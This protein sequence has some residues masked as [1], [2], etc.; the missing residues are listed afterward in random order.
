MHPRTRTL[1]AILGV[2]VLGV[3]ACSSSTEQSD[4]TTQSPSPTAAPPPNLPVVLTPVVANVIAAP[5]PAP[6]TDGRTHLA[7]ELELT[8]VL[9][10]E[11][12]LTSIAVR[13]GGQP[14]LTLS[15]D[16]LGYWTR[17]LGSPTPT[18]KLGPGQSGV[19]W[20]DVVVDN[21]KVPTDLVHTV[22][23]AVP[24][25]SPPM[26][27]A[28]LD[29]EVAPV[30]VQTRKS[31]VIAPPLDGPGW[32]DGDGCCD[33]TGHRN[34]VNPISGSLWV[35]ERFAIDYVQL[36]PNG[37]V[38]TGDPTKLESYPYFGTGIHAV[39]DGPV[40]AVMDGLPEQVPTKT[41]TG[42]RLE[43]YGGN[44]IVQDI[45]DGNYAFYA[46]LKTGSLKVKVGDQLTTGQAIAALGNSGNT[47][48]PHLHFHVM[49]TPD[50]LRS[51]GLPFL[52]DSFKLDNRIASMDD[53]G[54]L[55]Q[56]KPAVMQPGF[57][58]RDESSASPLVLDVMTYETR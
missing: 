12:T 18:T 49:S 44:H 26:I 33:M 35:A 50:P 2:L 42:L 47:D 4:R 19:V 37:M 13:A 1:A 58:A 54:P 52:I 9:G 28:A 3:G 48:A 51:N 25:P 46:H 39:A 38:T 7:Y 40:V 30:T 10:Q 34:A 29:E 20:L 53:L 41:P 17:A 32:L 31:P 8:N 11:V 36:Q 45:G 55:L 21:D 43:E 22:G 56:G 24:K 27:P 15:G 5:V 16:K 14:L 6:S 23:V 57:T